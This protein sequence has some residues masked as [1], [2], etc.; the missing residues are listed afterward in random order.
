MPGDDAVTAA[1]LA[2]VAALN[3]KY[4]EGEEIFYFFHRERLYNKSNNVWIGWER[5]RGA[6]MEFN[7]LVQ[8]LS[9]TS[10]V[11]K[12]SDA[13]PF[14]C[15]RYVITLDS[16]TIL[17]IGMAKR[18]IGTMAHPLNRPLIDVRRGVVTKGYGLIQPH[19]EIESAGGT[20]FS[21][22]FTNQDGID[23]YSGAL[24]DVYQD[25][26]GEGIFTGKGIYDLGTFQ[27]VLKG[28][29]PENTVLSHDL[30][31][32]SYLRAGLATDLILTD[33][34][35]AQYHAY[36][37][38]QHRWIRGDWQLLSY[39]LPM[40]KNIGSKKI[41]NPL[42]ELSKWKMY[43]NLRRSLLSPAMML[44]F[45][46]AATILPGNLAV[47]LGFL[48]L[49]M[50]LP[51]MGAIASSL[52]SLVSRNSRTRRYIPVIDSLK[53]ALL[54]GLLEISFL[55]YQAWLAVSAILLTL[56]RLLITRSN[57]LEWVTSA[58]SEARRITS[59]GGYYSWMQ[60][61]I[62][63]TLA[64][65]LL[66]ALTTRG[67]WVLLLPFALMWLASPALARA[68]GKETEE[69][70]PSDPEERL[71]L[72]KTARKTWRYFEE[73]S[74]K[75]THF[76]APDNYQAEP[77]RGVAARTSPTNIGF[78]LLAA[79]TARDMGYIGAI[80][81][82]ELLEKAIATVEG[83]PKWNGHLYN[84]YDTGT[85]KPLFP[86][87]IS[88]VDSGNFT[89]YLMTLEQGLREYLECPL[90]DQRF[91]EGLY[92]TVSCAEATI[93]PIWQQAVR[94]AREAAEPLAEAPAP[95]IRSMY[96]ALVS[97]LSQ[98][99]D[100]SVESDVWL[101]KAKQ[102]VQAQLDMLNGYCA[103][104]LVL[105][106]LPEPLRAY[107][108]ENAFT[109][110]GTLL[111]MLTGICSF[112]ELPARLRAAEL[113]ARHMIDQ[114][115]PAQ[116]EAGGEAAVWL[117]RLHAALSE[118][119]ERSLRAVLRHTALINRVHALA[120]AVRFRPLYSEK[121]KLLSIGY[122]IEDSKLTDSYYDLLASEAR[123]ASYIAISNGEI[124]SAHWFS[125]GRTLTVVGKYKG[126]VSWTGT[127]FEYL[128]P[129]LIM[130]SYRNTLLDETCS[131][132][133]KSQ[134]K[135]GKTRNMPWGMSE[136]AYNSLDKRNDYQYKAIGV[137][138]LGLKRG[139]SENSVVAPYAT[140]LALLVAP[141]EAIKNIARLKSE[142]IDG[143]YG[144]YESADYTKER[145]Y[146]E[147]KRVVIKSFMA[148]HQGMTLLSINEYL[149]ANRMQ[150][151]FLKNPA[152][153]AYRHLLQ[154][155]V[156]ANIAMTRTTREKVAPLT[157]KFSKQEL[158]VRMCGVPN[159]VLPRAHILSNGNYSILLTDAGTGFSKNKVASITRW[160]EDR[161]LDPFG[162][163][164]Y[165]RDAESG[166]V[167]SAAYAPL[168][169]TPDEYEV[170]FSDDKAVY[171]RSDGEIDTRTEVYVTTD[172]NA[173][174]RKL[175]LKNNGEAARTI[176]ITSYCEIVLAPRAA[177][178]AHMAFSN[179]F[180]ETDFYAQG[181]MVTA[182]RRPRSAQEKELWLGAFLVQNTETAEE[183]EFETDRLQ[184]L[185]RG[186]DARRPRVLS[187][188]QPL[189]GTVGAVLD[190]IISLRT[191]VTVQPGRTVSVSF[192]TIVAE[193]RDHLI[194]A[195]KS[196]DTPRDVE[197]AAHRAFERS[198][199]E[200]KYRDFK[201]SE[202]VL[203]LDILPHIL[204]LS[205]ARRENS[206]LIRLNHRGQPSLWRYAISGDQPILLV[207]LDEENQIPLLHEAIKAHEY[208]RLMDVAVDLVI[209]VS[210][211]H[212]YISPLRDL[213]MGIVES[214][215]RFASIL[216]PEDVVL[217]NR[218]D[219][220]EADLSLLIAAARVFLQGGK[221]SMEK[222]LEA[223]GIRPLP[224]K[225]Q[226]SGDTAEYTPA[227]QEEHPLLYDNG[228]GGF[229]P[230]GR[231]YIL[232]LGKGNTPAPWI[233]VIANPNFGFLCSESGSGYTWCDNS[234]EY[235]LTPWSNDAVSD[236][237]GEV[238][239]LSDRETGCVFT[240]TALPV[241]DSGDYGARHGFG[242]S[243]FTHECYG[244]S[245]TLTQFVPVRD[246]VKIS[247]L[248][249]KNMTGKVRRLCAAYY[250]RPVLGVSDQTTAMHVQT[251]QNESGM[252]MMENPYN[253]D[254]PGRVVFM[255][256]SIRERSLTGDRCEFFGRGGVDAPD[257]LLR[258]CLSGALG[259][260]LD[261]CGA[262]RA[263]I[264]LEPNE[265][266]TIV[267]LL[268]AAESPAAAKRLS[269]RYLTAQRAHA[270]LT[271]VVSYWES[272]LGEVRVETPDAAMNLLQNG[273]LLYQVIS[274]RLW[275]RTGFYQSGGAY[276]FR[277]QLQDVLAVAAT[278][279]GMAKKQILL[280]ARHQFTEGDVQ[281]WWHEPQGSGVRTRFSDDFLWL[282][283]VTAEYVRIT[284]DSSILQETIPF[285]RGAAL[286]ELERERYEK[287][288]VSSEKATL[289]EHCLRAIYR[290]L[291]FGEHGLPLMG[292][293]DWN[294][295]M[296]TVGEKGL[297]ESVWL[298]WFLSSVLERFSVLCANDGDEQT[299]ATFLDARRTLLINMEEY[300]WDG[301][302]YRRAYFDEGTALGSIHS[303]DCKIDSIAQSWAVL[304]G[305]GEPERARRA[306]V[307]LE[308]Y[309]VNRE[310]GL[311]KLLTPP[312]DK[313]S[314]EPGY[315][316]GY[317]P[318]V[319]ENGGQYTHA[320]AW[321]IIA[322]A[323]LGEG[324]KALELYDLINPI[325]H[326]SSYRSFVKYKTEPYVL[327]ADVYA[328]W[329]HTGRGGWSWYTGAAGWL[330]RAGLESI[331]GVRKE[332]DQLYI[333]PCIPARWLGF[334][335]EYRYFSAIYHIAVRNPDHAQSGVLRVAVDGK[336]VL[337]AVALQNDAAEHRVDVLM[338]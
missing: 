210:E 338:G 313:G 93:T 307:S 68:V 72:E 171:R 131:F 199:I 326:T 279:P 126:L 237:P 136:A 83:L 92:A 78:G 128:M 227:A 255:D 186:N 97:L 201:A 143:P 243:V 22:I 138:W 265:E 113:Q 79:L 10:F 41:T 240:P 305:G 224:G 249:I 112:G 182:K 198:R 65:L 122:S 222:Q 310:D 228:L 70:V 256:C 140:F 31:E 300:A 320:A 166:A 316:K 45:L 142:Q 325:H 284:G 151:R 184:F 232:R 89:G 297:G 290:A 161:T 139:L 221:G 56:T 281:H 229:R 283:F 247:L 15:I 203:F 63:Q 317:V 242:Y 280:H 257:C 100:A 105:S 259:I 236:P 114:P 61:A 106:E 50:L 204:F 278:N 95:D 304:S 162:T 285:I 225:T 167:W 2:G 298:G 66:A 32:G 303:Q 64:I 123:L 94:Q 88:T 239:Y 207:Q 323:K 137:P 44:F 277:D 262:I 108:R 150:E 67:E 329:P 1:A 53:S 172:E 177:D 99:D 39:L 54:Q 3:A 331:L 302:W 158:P 119:A 289:Y 181:R 169:K 24:S 148:H 59:L 57:L 60:A 81:M 246:T 118:T 37:A 286:M 293:G 328:V 292:G 196:F 324:A 266:K 13:P 234:H 195:A 90:I 267:Y 334:G 270:A 212:S 117:L 16:E 250:M 200:T 135:F 43:D 42:S 261:P 276:G 11:C 194:A 291:R 29:I 211:E 51:F 248:T 109:E 84:W 301:S 312:F 321:A 36:A 154:E 238:I 155:K 230:D 124:P 96:A 164:F 175:T 315:I 309:L 111:Q 263:E 268:G 55:P 27:A 141:R 14:E 251:S 318:G 8:G 7:D 311:I 38:R 306:M 209:I 254:F 233:N 173:E 102:Q 275:A 231:E 107:S 75:E 197:V 264:S 85:L 220:T 52:L 133:V 28:T 180:V 74:G 149:N 159:S 308:D 49:S 76:L 260:G 205:P 282:P 82:L 23:P 252:L 163:F 130:K 187:G 319:R 271:S 253:E 327:A 77:Y 314:S 189:S 332:G 269:G 132:A 168:N 125:M 174:I 46:L 58:D 296:N 223:L 4:A 274:C 335:V 160:R 288:V 69:P 145:L 30:L 144:F 153:R 218:T 216:C 48:L 185:G 115:E 258:D 17:P 245:Q 272:A 98:L 273:W 25:L 241:R 337:G 91:F 127:M 336:E 190:P 226:F 217:L 21:R 219:M 183:I 208:W 71:E 176:E 86:A 152:V 18:L 40:I 129:L 9:D 299:A 20:L 322:F 147:T 5:K 170:E 62:W 333:E 120:A 121:K 192:V 156:P 295:G 110:I 35:P 191:R 165:L 215:K 146:F 116:P 294:D 80:E 87:Y 213:A 179:L 6:I 134:I 178:L 19:I 193:S 235:R 73:F 214:Y 188:S 34:F 103:A 26:F 12:S 157:F 202:I 47:W 244:V 206:A 101:Y 330:Y 104:Y 33:G 287:A